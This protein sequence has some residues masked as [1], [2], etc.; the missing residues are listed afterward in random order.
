MKLE[1]GTFGSIGSTNKEKVVSKEDDLRSLIE[2]GAIKEERE[3]CGKKFQLRTLSAKERLS[4]LKSLNENPNEEDLFN[5]NI[6]TLAYSIVSINGKL[7]EDYYEGNKDDIISLKCEIISNF[8]S[9]LITQ[10]LKFYS[11]ITDRGDIQFSVD[12]VKK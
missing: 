1:H 8:Q 12:Q 3:I 6:T 5:F 11:E 10:L 7:L 2:L 9:S 4:L